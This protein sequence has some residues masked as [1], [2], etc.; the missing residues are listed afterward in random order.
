[1]TF[2]GKQNTDYTMFFASE[3]MANLCMCI[4]ERKK[5]QQSKQF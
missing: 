4:T 5:T 3:G 2:H 1:M